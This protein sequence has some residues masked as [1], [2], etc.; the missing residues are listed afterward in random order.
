[1]LIQWLALLLAAVASAQDSLV[2]DPQPPDGRPFYLVMGAESTGN[3]YVVSL[4]MALG[5]AG[6]A[7]HDQPFDYAR[8]RHHDWPLRVRWD[9]MM[10]RHFASLP[11]LVMHRS[12]PHANQWPQPLEM[13][14]QLLEIGFRPYLLVPQRNLTSVVHSQVRHRHVH[15]ASEAVENLLRAHNLINQT[16]PLLDALQVPH[17]RVSHSQ[18]A[19]PDYVRQLAAQLNLTWSRRTKLPRYKHH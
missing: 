12:L 16:L 4:L 8:D 9:Y 17:V 1:M 5:C 18:L 10:R 11:C 7:G 15:N 6:A 14:E 13:I 3:R 19:S 2:L